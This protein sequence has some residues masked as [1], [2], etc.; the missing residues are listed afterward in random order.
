MVIPSRVPLNSSNNGGYFTLDDVDVF[1]H[2]AAFLLN[3]KK[4]EHAEKK[5]LF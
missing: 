5:Q 2:H 3:R 1:V 4:P